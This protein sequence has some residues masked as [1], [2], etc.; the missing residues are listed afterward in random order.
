MKDPRLGVFRP[1]QLLAEAGGC[2]RRTIGS[3]VEPNLARM[4]TLG[5]D[6]I[7]GAKLLQLRFGRAGAFQPEQAVVHRDRRA[8]FIRVSDGAAI[9]RYWDDSRPVAVPLETLSLPPEEQPYPVRRAAAGADARRAG[10]SAGELRLGFRA[11]AGRAPRA[12]L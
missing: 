2:P 10:T 9:I 12:R 5:L 11:G 1:I 4:Y 7:A 8:R 3:G 6:T